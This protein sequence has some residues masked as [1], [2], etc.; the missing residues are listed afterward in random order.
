MTGMTLGGQHALVSGAARGIGAAIAYAL[1]AAG[2]R[3]SLL[4]RNLD[5]L[6]VT[7]AKII[8]AHP[9]SQTSAIAADVSD[10]AA[11]HKAMTNAHAHFGPV[12]LLVNNAGQAESAPFVK[13]D[14]A[15]WQRMLAV[16]LTGTFLCTRAVLPDMLNAGFGR[17]VNIAS[18]AGLRGYAYVAAYTASKHGVIGLTRALALEVAMKGITVNAVCPGYTDTDMVRDA[19]GKI[20]TQTGR[21]ADEARAALV[22]TNPQQHLIDPKEIAQTV[23]WL[24]GPHTASI[25]GQCLAIAGGEVMV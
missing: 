14:E 3:V 20:V 4:G 8:E 16:N 6:S 18:T 11:V 23:V 9:A 10:S 12:Q 22:R 15:L 13:T 1:A 21:S 24:C 7:A 2:A 19:I 17:I 25:T 5:A